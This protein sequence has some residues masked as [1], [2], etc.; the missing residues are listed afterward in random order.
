MLDS[1]LRPNA[2][3]DALPP[4]PVSV[5]CGVPLSYS[6]QVAEQFSSCRQT[7]R[8]ERGRLDATQFQVTVTRPALR[9]SRRALVPLMRRRGRLDRLK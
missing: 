3:S 7:A 6:A 8:Q 2:D 1:Q 5:S 9:H 4:K